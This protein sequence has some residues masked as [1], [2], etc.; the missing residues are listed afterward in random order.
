MQS[1]R[2]TSPLPDGI[3][4]AQQAAP[5]VQ[6]PKRLKEHSMKNSWHWQITLPITL[7]IALGIGFPLTVEAQSKSRKPSSTTSSN[8]NPPPHLT[9]QN[10]PLT[11]ETKATTSMAPIVKRVA[12]SVAN[13]YSTVI[14]RDRSGGGAHPFLNDPMFRRFFGDDFGQ[15][16]RP[17]ERKT[18]S[19]G[20][21][22]VVSPNGYLLTA[23]HVVED[24]DTV[25][26]ALTLPGGEREFDAK[27]I[28][29]DKATDIAVLK[30]ESS[31]NLP[32]ITLGDSDSLE[33]G[34]MLLAIG[35]PFGVGQTVTLGIVSGLGRGGFGING[36]EDFIQTDAAI[37]PG[38]SGGALVDA[39]GR[40]VGINTAII[41]G[42]GGFQGV[43]F[44]VPINMA[45]YVM[46]RITTE[47]KVRRG[48]LGINIQ[49]L[50]PRLAKEF[51]LPEGAAG[52][53]VGGVTSGSAAEKAGLRGGDVILEVN[54][55]KVPEPRNLQL[56]IAQ[57]APG[58]KV[59]LKVL[60][61]DVGKKPSEKTIV[62]TLAELPADLASGATNDGDS[63]KGQDT[64]DGVE[65]SDLDSKTRRQFEIPN[66][67]RGALVSN[68]E[69]GSP[70]A[71]AGL[72]PGDVILQINHQP[73]TNADEAV[74]LSEK[75]KD[76]RVLLQIW[77]GGRG[78]Q[79]GTRYVVIESPKDKSK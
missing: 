25:K 7:A 52:V 57:N 29:A 43:G 12:P 53:L 70:A 40:L 41:S 36:Y 71:E 46:D 54:G 48:Y 50:D 62:A 21:G 66:R 2:V 16:S 15:R 77:R 75:A 30:I 1:Y 68:I 31:T 39:E 18:Q 64:L 22:V 47:G 69:D 79:G 26:V 17:R 23:N 4:S 24:A 78:G 45:R 34:D 74:A 11:K 56:L 33:V 73:V 5:D 63:G 32:A 8:T 42:S 28:G 38:N 19:L 44:A 14:I 35:N 72:L 65:V 49:P 51:N 55:K 60:R 67:V 9:V 6:V 58:T 10:S 37:N 13:I 59:N 20:S 61:S 76:G 27:V 3:N